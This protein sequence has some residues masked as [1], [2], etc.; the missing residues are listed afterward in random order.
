LVVLVRGRSHEDALLFL[1][2]LPLHL[3]SCFLPHDF[4]LPKTQG[5]GSVSNY[6]S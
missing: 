2:V 6:R 5:A 3:Q 4:S 1:Q